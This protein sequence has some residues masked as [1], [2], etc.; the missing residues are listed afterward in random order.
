MKNVCQ[1]IASMLKPVFGWGVFVSLF[2]G[3]LT[4]FGYLVAIFIGGAQIAPSYVAKN[5]M[6]YTYQAEDSSLVATVFDETYQL[7]IKE[8]ESETTLGLLDADD[9]GLHG[10]LYSIDAEGNPVI[11]QVDLN[12]DNDE[13]QIALRKDLENTYFKYGVNVD[14]TIHFLTGKVSD[15]RMATTTEIDKAADLRLDLAEGGVR[16]YTQSKDKE[17]GK[18]KDSFVHVG[19]TGGTGA[20]ICTFLYKEFFPIL[21]Y[22]STCCILLGLLTMYLSGE[23]AL[24]V[25]KKES[26]KHEG[27]M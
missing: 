4:F 12:Y 13:E 20:E 18:M 23:Q 16:L 21:V 3:G 5:G 22:I 1:K 11:A 19:Y 10:Q 15:S 7:G 6:V 8:G 27:E 26:S 17:T 2:L 24:T 25:G 9:N 14:G